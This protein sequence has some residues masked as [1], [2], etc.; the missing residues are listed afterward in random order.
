MI[1]HR[2]MYDPNSCLSKAKDDEPLFVLMGRDASTLVAITA[3]I[4]HRID[5]GKNKPDDEQILEA[6]DVVKSMLSYRAAHMPLL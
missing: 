6:L 1:K 4:N 3:W 5:T 2:E